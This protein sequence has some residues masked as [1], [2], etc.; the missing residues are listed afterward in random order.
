[1]LEF[2]VLRKHEKTPHAIVGLGGAALEAD[3]ALHRTSKKGIIKCMPKA[4]KKTKVDDLTRQV[5]A[6][7]YGFIPYPHHY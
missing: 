2:G 1:M 4:I 5:L 6:T 3:V 7:S